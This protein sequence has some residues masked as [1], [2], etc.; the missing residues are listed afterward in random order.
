MW[1]NWQLL[2]KYLKKQKKNKDKDKDKTFCFVG[3]DEEKSTPRRK[4]SNDTCGWRL[5]KQKHNNASVDDDASARVVK[6]P[7]RP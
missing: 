4:K 6:Q 3:C 2:V 1:G 7:P 5:V